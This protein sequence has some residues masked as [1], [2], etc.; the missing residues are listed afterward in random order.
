MRYSLHR[1]TCT[2]AS[3]RR[4]ISCTPRPSPT[5]PI[6]GTRATGRFLAAGHSA[7]RSNHGCGLAIDVAALVRGTTYG[8]EDTAFASAEYQWLHANGPAYGF[9]N[10]AFAKPV[11]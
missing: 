3:R 8:T 10:P 11:G 4:G 9:I 6:C 1:P 7:G 2:R 5:A